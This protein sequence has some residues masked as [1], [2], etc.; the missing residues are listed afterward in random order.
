MTDAFCRL[1]G[2]N[3]PTDLIEGLMLDRY[4]LTADAARTIVRVAGEGDPLAADLVRWSGQELG[5]LAVGVIRQLDIAD[6]AV[7]VVLV[8]S[9]YNIGLPL[10]DPMRETIQGVAPKAH[11]IRL[12][13]PPV[14]GGVMLAMEQA[15]LNPLP[16]RERL[17]AETAETLK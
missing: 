11:L 4:R 2:A 8:G 3:N 5:N 13:V 15:R 1:V 17:I 10:I 12:N 7:D 14:V 6:L 9:L 16:L